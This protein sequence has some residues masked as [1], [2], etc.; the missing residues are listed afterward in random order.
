MKLSKKL[1]IKIDEISD[2]RNNGDGWWIYLTK[3][4]ADFNF[5]PYYPMRVIHENTFEKCIERVKMA[6]KV[7]KE[8]L[9]KFPNLK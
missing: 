2:E 7:T 5:D 9:E 8:D 6:Q 1:S 4:Y 3:E